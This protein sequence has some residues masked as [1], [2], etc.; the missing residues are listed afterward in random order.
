M[1]G[2]EGELLDVA[3]ALAGDLEGGDGDADARE[4]GEGAEEEEAGEDREGDSEVVQ[5]ICR[6][7]GRVGGRRGE[8]AEGRRRAEGVDRGGKGRGWL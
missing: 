2:E 3:E 5:V 6:G 1:E 7:S 8:N 4:E